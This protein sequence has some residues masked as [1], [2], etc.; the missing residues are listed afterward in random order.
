MKILLVSPR[1][2]DTFWS[3]K[4]AIRFV[5]RKASMAPLGLL[6]VA[7]MLPPEWELKLV[8]LNVEKLKDENLRWADYVLL[9]AMI[10]QKDSVREIVARCAAFEKTIIAGGPLFTTGHAAFPE[11]QHFV[12]GEAEEVM[13]QVVADMRSGRLQSIYRAPHRPDITHTPM[14]RWDLIK[15]RYYV[16]MSVQFS[17]GCPFDCEFCDI[18]VMNGRVPRTKTPA[19]LIAE[20][21][22]LRQR[23]WKDMVFIVDD[24]FIGNKARTKTL[25]H[26]LIEWRKRT[27]TSIGFLTEA[28][29]NLADDP[30]LCALMVEAGF[31]KVFVGIETPSVE[32]LAECH[33][34]QNRNRDLVASVK[35]L[36]RAGLEVMGG[37]I[38]G[39]DS[40]QSD[41]FK[42]QFEFIQRSG[43]ATAMVGL[44]TALPQTRLWQRLK[45]EGRLEAESSGNNTDAALNFKPKL[46]RDFLQSGYRELVKKL[47][48]PRN[49]YQ[50]IRT[51]LKSHRPVGPRRRLS[52]ADLIAFLK[53]FWVLGVW[54]RGRVGYWRLFWG[55]LIRR[56]RQFPHAIELA[57]LGYHFRR[58]A[59]SL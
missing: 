33:K 23:G 1:T 21:D 17:R 55:T 9:G 49:Y 39:F 38:V 4:H 32:A 40:D 53:S 59:K 37:F 20:L 26:A 19:Q 58:V 31:R 36:Q 12:L 25:L 8:D 14:P 5:S 34:V 48:E 43:V 11:I 27:R 18:I 35:T 30:E 42:R 3:F 57:I 54:H 22:A 46:N 10:V 13:P 51:F 45:T 2:P 29:V 16:T 7:A 24:N 15:F 28:S 41:I 50:R 56:P 47:Y 44:L 52:R 6:T